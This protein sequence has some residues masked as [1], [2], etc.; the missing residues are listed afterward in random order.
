MLMNANAL[1]LWKR[2]GGSALGRRLFSLGVGLKA[3]YF[4]TVRA[5]VRELEP[6]RSL[7]WAKKRW[8][9]HN[10]I[11]TFHAI[12]MCNLAELAMGLVAE[13]TVPP[14]HRWIPIGI[15]A[16]YLARAE[17]SLT[18]EAKLDPIPEFAAEKFDVD[19]QV[20]I[21]DDSGGL[22]CSVTIPIRVSPRKVTG[23]F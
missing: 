21:R 9:V 19:V 17:S 12:A 3:P 2:L 18:A 23:E 20:E 5:H 1:H 11:G 13:A 6:G 8:R 22:V 14:T 16:K 7:V 15:E 10:H 4:L